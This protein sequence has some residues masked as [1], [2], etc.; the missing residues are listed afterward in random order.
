MI[1]ADE[2]TQI[3]KIMRLKLKYLSPNELRVDP[4][5]K[6]LFEP[7]DPKELDYLARSI[8]EHGLINPITIT[9]DNLIIAGEQR[10]WAAVQVGF[11]KL[12]VIVRKPKDELELEEIRID[13]NLMR[14]SLAGYVT[15]RAIQRKTE[16][17]L[18]RRASDGVR[19][20]QTLDEVGDKI[21]QEIA[22]ETG[23]SV[24]RIKEIRST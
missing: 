8:Q 5:N 18:E 6:E 2:A 15:F 16:I 24:S 4:K 3:E 23:Y 19:P 17:K 1:V 22:E 14:R 7:L 12:P 11:D 10:Y 20:T 21:N 13:E 9:E